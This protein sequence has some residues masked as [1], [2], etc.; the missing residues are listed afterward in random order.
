MSG[1]CLALVAIPNEQD[2]DHQGAEDRNADPPR[3]RWE[4][5][6]RVVAD[7]DG[8]GGEDK[9]SSVSVIPLGKR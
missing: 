5:A 7:Q 9:H 1:S 3:K 2:A 8:Q 4:H 6:T